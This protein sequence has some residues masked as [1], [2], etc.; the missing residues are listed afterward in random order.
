MALDGVLRVYDR[1]FKLRFESETLPATDLS[2]LTD[3][4][5][6]LWLSRT[7][8]V[9]PVSLDAAPDGPFPVM[10]LDLA[11]DPI[12]ARPLTRDNPYEAVF[13]PRQ[14]RLEAI[15]QDLILS[16]AEPGPAGSGATDGSWMLPAGG[17]DCLLTDPGPMLLALSDGVDLHTIEIDVTWCPPSFRGDLGDWISFVILQ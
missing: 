3:L 1:D 4:T 14:E 8:L 16:G 6:T 13:G 12:V 2:N 9:F 10:I 7:E 11:A 5:G 17:G 15:R